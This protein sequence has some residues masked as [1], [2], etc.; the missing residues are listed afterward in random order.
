MVFYLKMHPFGKVVS[1][2]PASFR[3]MAVGLRA[4]DATELESVC[5][6]VDGTKS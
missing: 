3:M 1:M 2:V 6:L 5:L 4:M